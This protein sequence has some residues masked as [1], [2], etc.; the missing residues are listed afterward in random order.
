MIARA[1]AVLPNCTS[2]R[3]YGSSEAP[4]VSLGIAS[5]D[6]YERG[7]NTDGCIYNHEVRIV[8]IATG[9]RLGVGEQGEILT[10]GPEVML[11]YTDPGQSAE[12][13]D[14]DGFFR[15]GD[16]G[17]AD[18]EHYITVSGRLKDIIIR[19]GENISAKEIEDVLHR[20]PNINEVAI[21]GMPHRRMGETPCA[22]VIMKPGMKIDLAEVT[23][24]LESNGMARQKFPECLVIVDELPRT[25]SGKVLKHVLRKR[26]AAELKVDQ[27]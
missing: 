2:F 3:V 9:V 26:A 15:T 14:A 24:F 7:A 12:A 21:V 1:R 23:R 8:D 6:S 5:G 18:S 19:G 13:F 11:G 22:Y 25:A 17:S 4:T 20:H 16:L 27:V 10:R